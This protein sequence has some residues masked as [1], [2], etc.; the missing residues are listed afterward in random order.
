[1]RMSDCMGKFQ[2]QV[3]RFESWTAAEVQAKRLGLK[4]IFV[5][6]ASSYFKSKNKVGFIADKNLYV[7]D[8]RK[9]V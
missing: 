2:Y 3:Y 1:M 6:N 8:L 4:E 7:Y 9:S 5:P